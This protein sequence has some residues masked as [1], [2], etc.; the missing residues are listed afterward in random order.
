MNLGQLRAFHA[1]ATYRGFSAAAQTLGVTQP[2]VTEHIRALEDALGTG[3]FARRGGTVELTAEGRSLLPQVH[4]GVMA[5][6]ELG[7]RISA[8]KDLRVGH[9]SIGICAPFVVMPILRQFMAEY[10]GIQVDVRLDNSIRLLDLV[11]SHTVDLAIVTM[12]EPDPDFLC[13]QL[14]DQQVLVLVSSNH[15]WSQRQSLAVEELAE[16]PFVMRELGSMTRQIFEQGLA[17]AGVEV[18]LRLVLGSREVVPDNDSDL[19][20]NGT[21]NARI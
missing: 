19:K 11:A 4:R 20:P 7:T 13:S 1:V 18:D 5:L 3:R 8:G 21:L 6:D 16:V 14:V 12:T 15:P 10:P 17:E 2:A 9:L